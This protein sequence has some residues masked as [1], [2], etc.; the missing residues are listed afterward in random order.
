MNKQSD[1]SDPLSRIEAIAFEGGGIR[2]LAYGRALRLLAPHLPD[3]LP[4]LR[5]LVGTSAG[6]IT[7]MLV[8]LGATAEQLERIVGSTPWAE[9]RDGDWGLIRDGW[10][11][12]RRLGYYRLD[13]PRRWLADRIAELGWSPELTFRE[14][15]NRTGRQLHV[16]ATNES[17]RSLTVFDH[18]RHPRIPVLD[19][20]LSSM[21]VPFFFPLVEIAGDLYSDGGLLANQAMTLLDDLALDRTLGMRVDSDAEL[22]ERWPRPRTVLHRAWGLFEALIRHANGGHVPERYQSRIL[23]IRVGNL[24]ALRFKLS[25]DERRF[26]ISRSE[27]AFRAFAASPTEV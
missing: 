11:L 18:M 15:F 6:A 1:H 9:F 12:F 26:L 8:A 23:C 7:A 24:P 17:T 19:A 25:L 2:G 14:H 13:Y 22:A 21:A 3:G 20:T 5:V 27:E 10:R 16:I 4:S